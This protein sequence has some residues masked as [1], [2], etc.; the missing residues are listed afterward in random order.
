M[1]NFQVSQAA[2]EKILQQLQEAD[3]GGRALRVR[4]TGWTADDFEYRLEVLPVE[5]VGDSDMLIEDEE[6]PIIL[7]NDSIER[8]RG[9]E[10]KYEDSPMGAGFSIDNP[11]PVWTNPLEKKVQKVLDTSI[12]PGIAAHGG[13]VILHR[14]EGDR[15]FVEFSGGCQGCGL[16]SVTL[17]QG[18]NRAIMDQMPE[19]ADVIDIT[20]HAAGENPFYKPSQ[21][22]GAESPVAP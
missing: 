22:E 19:I 5:M 17:K 18:V 10:L 7:A 2:K 6:L 8:L 20:D 14:V 11:N 9:A 16:S 21:V 12:N 3:R 13:K 1:T 4:I 15:A